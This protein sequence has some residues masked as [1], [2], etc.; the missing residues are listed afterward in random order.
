MQHCYEWVS[1]QRL[2]ESTCSNGHRSCVTIRLHCVSI[3][4]HCLSRWLEYIVCLFDCTGCLSEI[5]VNAVYLFPTQPVSWCRNIDFSAT[6]EERFYFGQKPSLDLYCLF[7][8]LFLAVPVCFNIMVYRLASVYMYAFS[9]LFRGLI[10][11]LIPNPPPPLSVSQWTSFLIIHSVISITSFSA[12]YRSLVSQRFVSKYY[13][14][15]YYPAIG[16]IWIYITHEAM[17]QNSLQWS[18]GA[19]TLNTFAIFSH[20]EP[21]ILCKWK[22]NKTSYDLLNV[23][24]RWVLSLTLPSTYIIHWSRQ[25]CCSRKDCTKNVAVI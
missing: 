21:S 19:M 16:P 4:L 10:Q 11:G 8:F 7:S 5:C 15:T 2:I 14:R 18:H 12:A 24:H 6:V 17:I 1:L 13:C 23:Y 3:W 9:T 25:S 22:F 20:S